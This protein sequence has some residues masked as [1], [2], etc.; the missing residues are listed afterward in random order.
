MY[1]AIV[2]GA[3]CAGSPLAMLLA[4][5]GHRVLIVDRATFPSDTMSTH[6]IQLPG[7]LRL[8]RWGLLDQV[9]AT[10][11]P[12]I[13]KGATRIGDNVVDIEFPKHGDV[14][15]LL[16]PRR[17]VLDKILVDAAVDAGAELAEGVSISELIYENDRVVGV[18]GH[19]SEGNFE[20]RGRFVV[21]ADG[22]HS[23]VARSV[24]APYEKFV[25]QK[26]AGYYSYF[27]DVE[28][29]GAE[30]Y[31]HDRCF[32][33]AFPTNDGLTTVA[34]VIPGA[35]LND[36][37]RDVQGSFYGTLDELG[38]IGERIRAGTRAEK[39]VGVGE[40]PNFI[41]HPYGPGW[42]LA[43]DSYYH[44]DPSPADGISDAFRAADFL[45]SALDD[46]LSDRIDEAAG[47]A[48]YQEQHDKVAVPMMELTTEMSDLEKT[49]AERADS[50]LRI[51]M[52]DADE[53]N[54]SNGQH[55]A[56]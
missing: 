33:V 51:R 19:T 25:N 41:R 4:R 46:M 16:A 32:C 40:M 54:D 1:D 6:F 12:P 21:G 17:T 3:R 31:F 34:L 18:R 38:T 42:V 8:S 43:G 52:L 7:M 53:I 27:S 20:Q 13:Q 10:G 35:E 49:P 14:D 55:V 9:K 22:R 48:R 24:E 37:R 28:M 47:L 11:C 29:E 56:A 2:V 39:L 5:K 23:V 50:F 26:G 15:G 44:K 36:L 45:S 30:I